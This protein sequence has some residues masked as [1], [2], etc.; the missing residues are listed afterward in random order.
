MVPTLSSLEKSMKG[1]K[2]E[3]FMTTKTL[4]KIFKEKL[5]VR[6]NLNKLFSVYSYANFFSRSD[7]KKMIYYYSSVPLSLM[8]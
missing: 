4:T 5:D 1:R 3:L 6:N 8:L 2:M 7:L